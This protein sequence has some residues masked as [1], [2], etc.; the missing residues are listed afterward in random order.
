M[1]SFSPGY[2]EPARVD[3]VL[4]SDPSFS[5]HSSSVAYICKVLHNVRDVRWGRCVECNCRSR[6]LPGRILHLGK[7]CA[8]SCACWDDSGVAQ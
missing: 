3:L 4:C 8:L 5:I 1:A 6:S 2:R 7:P